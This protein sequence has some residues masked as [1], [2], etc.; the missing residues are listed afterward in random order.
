MRNHKTVFCK[1]RI[2]EIVKLNTHRSWVA[3]LPWL[4]QTSSFSSG[5]ILGKSHRKYNCIECLED[6]S[7]HHFAFQNNI[8]YKIFRFSISQ[9]R[10]KP[11]NVFDYVTAS[12]DLHFWW[13]YCSWI[14]SFRFW[15]SQSLWLLFCYSIF[16]FAGSCE[17]EK[18]N[19]HR[20]WERFYVMIC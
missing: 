9:G 2:G 14:Y 13:S 20:K 5:E 15:I 19:K 10:A 8:W 1:L 11:W 12:I 3:V 7:V 16:D 6:I 4:N 17:I 18:L